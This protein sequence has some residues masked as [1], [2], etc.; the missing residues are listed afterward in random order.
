MTDRIL[1]D[2]LSSYLKYTEDT[3]PPLSYHVWTGISMIAA[4][5]QRRVHMPWG[6]E[7]I[8]PNMYILLIGPSGKCRKGTAMGMGRDL[9][10]AVQGISLV[11]ESITREALI[12]FMKQNITNMPTEGGNV[13]FQCAVTCISPE[14]SVFLGQS[15]I[16]FLANLT[17]WF[18]S[19]DV[20]TY[21]TKN[22]GT[23]KIQGVCFNLL[24]ATAPDW[25]QS[26]FPQE[27]IGG[28]F[29]SRCIFIVE[30]EKR[31]IVPIPIFTE[32][33]AKLRQALIK[34]LEAIVTINGTYKFDKQAMAAYVAWY[35]EQEDI[36]KRGEIIID[37]PRF[38]GYCERRAT[39]V[40]KLCIII[41]ASRTDSTNIQ[42]KDFNQALA[43]L[44]AAELKMSKTFGGLGR[45]QYSDITESVL[46]YIMKRGEVKRS[47]L[48]R[49]FY[50]DMDTPT[51]K[52]VEEV[53]SQMKV[54]KIYHDP[55]QQEV[56]YKCSI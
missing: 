55:E 24:G 51:L 38:V 37:D 34:D 40:K 39:H 27:A 50:K 8:Y 2:W 53:L 10:T 33:H 25:M 54:I 36:T 5:L 44:K 6:H 3:E 21:E 1:P 11:S 26:M 14:L 47:E 4:A 18:D 23:D 32:D 31:Q 28:G 22:S 35:K 49:V 45:A 48:L 17:D 9:I 12:R 46:E 52:I 30:D 42:E 56:L 15:D 19:S 13:A 29:T 20:W 16:K 43:L 7:K 41:T